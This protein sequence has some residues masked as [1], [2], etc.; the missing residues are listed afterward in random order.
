MVGEGKG[1]QPECGEASAPTMPRAPWPL[2]WTV[3]PS[4]RHDGKSKRQTGT[5][6][7]LGELFQMLPAVSPLFGAVIISCYPKL[8]ERT[9]R[10]WSPVFLDSSLSSVKPSKPFLEI[11]NHLEI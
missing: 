4:S 3:G 7:A 9:L 10:L 2:V 11:N 6:E 8:T 5:R 1:V